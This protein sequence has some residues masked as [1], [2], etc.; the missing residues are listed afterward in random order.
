MQAWKFRLNSLSKGKTVEG[1]EGVGGREERLMHYLF[2]PLGDEELP[3]SFRRLK[4]NQRTENPNRHGTLQRSATHVFTFIY[5]KERFHGKDVFFCIIYRVYSSMYLR[6][7][8]KGIV[9][10]IKYK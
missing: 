2:R 3:P 7:K 10:L 9:L 4:I 1:R 8:S 5:Y 6:L